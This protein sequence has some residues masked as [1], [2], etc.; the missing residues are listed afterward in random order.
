MQFALLHS[1]QIDWPIL[2]QADCRVEENDY[3]YKIEISPKPTSVFVKFW[4]YCVPLLFHFL[5]L[6]VPVE[7]S[8]SFFYIILISW[9]FSSF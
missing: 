9:G 5:L 7:T 8:C 3:Y 2:D 1:A 4:N 6:S